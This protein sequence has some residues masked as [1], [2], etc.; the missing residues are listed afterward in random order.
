MPKYG[1][2]KKNLIAVCIFLRVDNIFYCIKNVFVFVRV[3]ITI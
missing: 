2:Y 3:Y 1:V